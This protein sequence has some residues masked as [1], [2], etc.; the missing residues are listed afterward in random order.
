[1]IDEPV[2]AKVRSPFVASTRML[3][4]SCTGHT[5]TSVSLQRDLSA[6]S[7]VV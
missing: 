6:W 4:G 5:R 2:A 7:I 1:M 3:C